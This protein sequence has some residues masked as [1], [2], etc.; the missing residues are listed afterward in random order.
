MTPNYPTTKGSEID[1]EK[2][3][4]EMAFDFSRDLKQRIES[5]EIKDTYIPPNHTFGYFSEREIDKFFIQMMINEQE[6]LF[7]SVYQKHGMEMLD[8]YI[9]TQREYIEGKG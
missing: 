9:E 6:K 1:M 4:R 2:L 8:H 7:Y 3:F 5:G